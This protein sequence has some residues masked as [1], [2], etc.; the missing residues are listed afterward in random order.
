MLSN[1]RESTRKAEINLRLA[2]FEFPPMQDVLLIGKRA[3]IGP[4]AAK[5][6]SDALSP[7]QYE[8]IPLEHELFEAAVVRRSLLKILPREK[9]FPVILEE[10]TRIASENTVIKIQVNATIQVNKVIDL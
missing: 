1:N 5:K 8:I 3:P 7:D 10:G 4:E 6:M 2:E 9:L